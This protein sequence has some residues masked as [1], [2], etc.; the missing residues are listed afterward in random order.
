MGKYLKKFDTHTEYETYIEG[1][2]VIL[3]NVSYCDDNK[4]VHYNPIVPDPYGG[5]DY[6]EIG[7]IKWATMN[8]GASSITDAGL[9]FQWGDTQGYTAAQVGVDK[10]FDLANYKY[11]DNGTTAMTKYNDIDEKANLEA[12]DDAAKV[13]WGG[14]WRTPTSQDIDTLIGAVDAEWVVEYQGSG[15][16]GVVC[17]Y[18]VD[19][20][21][22]L[23]LPA[24][25]VCRDDELQNVNYEGLYWTNI[26]GAGMGAERF[27]AVL[28]LSDADDSEL[29]SGIVYRERGQNIRP[30]AD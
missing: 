12:S 15:I 10:T 27:A 22:V 8:I 14:N 30:V 20:S 23:F 5:H 2:N 21:N 25:G 1:E 26:C 7:G 11:S 24:C 9:Y 18:K 16:N 29:Y 19:S 6:V 13:L 4:D 17:I 28:Y 3:P